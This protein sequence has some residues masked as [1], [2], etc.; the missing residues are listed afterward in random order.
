M[1]KKVTTEDLLEFMQEHMAT[2]G[3]I[4]DVN[5]R[6][7]TVKHE[8]L[9][10][11]DRKFASARHHVD[12]KFHEID[13]RFDTMD[14][15]FDKMDDR[16]DGMDD[17]FDTL[18]NKFD[19]VTNILHVKEIITDSQLQHLNSLKPAMIDTYGKQEC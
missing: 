14:N 2:K 12:T 19:T 10:V 15:R 11:M 4:A 3:D 1:K 8:I 6:I 5:A 13:D 17:R 16:F 9:D 18:E 7:S